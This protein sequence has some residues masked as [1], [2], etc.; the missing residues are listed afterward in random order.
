MRWL[1]LQHGGGTGTYWVQRSVDAPDTRATWG[2]CAY[3]P[4]FPSPLSFP[5]ETSLRSP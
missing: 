2:V 4:S 1:F 3:L 5:S